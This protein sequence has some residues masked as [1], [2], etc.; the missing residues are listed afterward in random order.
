[1]FRSGPLTRAR[2]NQIMRWVEKLPNDLR[3]VAKACNIYP[4]DLLTWY[5]AGQ[6]KDC[7]N[8]LYVELAWR[9]AEVRA[10]ARVR[11]YERVVAAADGGK[12]VKTVSKPDPANPGTPIVEITE[13]DVLPAAWAI[14]KLD[15][16]AE[17]SPWEVAPD[18]QQATELHAM[19]KELTP[20]PLLTDGSNQPILT[21]AAGPSDEQSEPDQEGD[22]APA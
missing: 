2:V 3:T 18:A 15:T 8:P 5:A 21:E 14:E 16:Q 19:M 13:E 1:M 7:Q 20:T 17:A 4:S 6:D 10:N 11:N 12:K 9:V 22:G